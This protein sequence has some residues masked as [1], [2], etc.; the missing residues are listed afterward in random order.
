MMQVPVSSHSEMVFHQAWNHI[1]DDLRSRDLL[2]NAEAGSLKY[3]HLGWGQ[4]REEA[5]LLLPK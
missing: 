5:W 1:V 2:S 4:G 3:V